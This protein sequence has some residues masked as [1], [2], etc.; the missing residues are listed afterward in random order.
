MFKHILIPTDGSALSERAIASAIRFA[1]SIGARVTGLHVAAGGGVSPLERCLRGDAHTRSRL[2]A[3]FAEQAKRYLEVIESAAKKA[4]IRSECLC[5]TGDA[6]FQEI[7]KTAENRRC[8]LIYMASHG[9]AGPSALLLG[10]ET[11]KV[12]I[13]SRTPVLVHRERNPPPVASRMKAAV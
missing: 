3:L 7:L 6:P 1:G 4:G 11:A 5:V 10:S 2:K 9:K 13:H 8:D 12:L